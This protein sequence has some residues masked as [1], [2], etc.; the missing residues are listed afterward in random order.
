LKLFVKEVAMFR[1]RGCSQLILALAS[2]LVLTACGGSGSQSKGPVASLEDVKSATVQIVAKGS[3]YPPQIGAGQQVK[4]G[5][6]SGFIVDPSGIAVTNNHV[7]SGA[8]SLEVYVGGEKEAHNA[9]ILG[10]SECSDLAV[11][12]IEGDGFP[13]L[14]WYEGEIKVGMDVYA[15]GFPLGDPEFTLTKGIVSKEKTAGDTPWSSVERVIEHDATINPGN[16]G[17]PLITPEGKVVAVNY[18]KSAA[19]KF[20]AAQYFAIARDEA[21]PIY[22]KLQQGQ[23]V[24]SVGLNGEVVNDGQGNTGVWVASVRSGTRADA[25]GIKGGD[26][27]LTMEGLVLGVDYTMSDYCKILRSHYEEDVLT[28]QILRFETE[29]VLEGQI[30]GRPL[31]VSFSFG[32][33]VGSEVATKPP[34]ESSTYSDYMNVTND[35]NEIQMEVP[36]EWNDIQDTTMWDYTAMLDVSSNLVDRDLFYAAPGVRFIAWNSDYLAVSSVEG[37]LDSRQE[38]SCAYEGRYEFEKSRY[39]GMYDVYSNCDGEG[40]P[41]RLVLV[42]EPKDPQEK[43]L[44]FLM[45]QVM[46]EDDLYA[47]DHILATFEVIGEIR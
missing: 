27:L 21:V 24:D 14:E 31:E 25:A 18:L 6:G 7:V 47:L 37:E 20:I 19:D 10:V 9:K 33:Q 4:A 15:V 38:L 8:A 36:V 32:K 22:E 11:I 44:L 23:D 30:N 42:V 35:Q 5:S 28:V 43:F 39:R 1:K 29:Q 17:G 34:T 16:S 26:I 13:Y 45:I 41:M 40:G 3:F 2:C 46:T 12:D